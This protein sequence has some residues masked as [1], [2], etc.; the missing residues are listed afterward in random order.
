MFRKGLEPLTP[1][2]NLGILPLRRTELWWTI[3]DLNRSPQACKASALPDELM[4]QIFDLFIFWWSRQPPSVSYD[5]LKIEVFVSP[6][7]LARLVQTR[8]V[9]PLILP[10]DDSKSPMYTSSNT[11]GYYWYLPLFAPLL[12]SWIEWQLGQRIC[13]LSKL[14]S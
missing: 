4:A 10:A 5:T 13:R 9:E 14:L 11:S 12:P 8:G 1:S 3:P 7:P 6:G 2:S